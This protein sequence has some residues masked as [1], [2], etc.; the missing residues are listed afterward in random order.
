MRVSPRRHTVAV[1]RLLLKLTQKEFADLMGVSP[2]TIQ[3]VELGSL[4]LSDTLAERISLR[5]GASIDWLLSGKPETP[6]TCEEDT[7]VVLTLE[8]AER[9][10]A[11][12]SGEMKNEQVWG[13][14]V[15]FRKFWYS[16]NAA[17]L[18]IGSVAVRQ[19]KYALFSFKVWKFARELADYFG[20]TFPSSGPI[21]NIWAQIGEWKHHRPSPARLAAYQA[22]INAAM[23]QLSADLGKQYPVNSMPPSARSS[24]KSPA[25]SKTKRPRVRK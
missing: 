15:V 4:K 18:D 20:T 11:F 10:L 13:S 9:A 24:P 12:S 17:L 8:D 5:T 21:K 2:K 25:K 19:R 14:Y 3:A 6:P 22:E 7:R 23:K 1:L 16:I